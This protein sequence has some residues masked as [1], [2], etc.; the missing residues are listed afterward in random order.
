VICFNK[1]LSTIQE[2]LEDGQPVQGQLV[3]GVTILVD[4]L[5]LLDDCGLA[6]LSGACDLHHDQSA[7]LQMTMRKKKK[8]RERWKE[9]ELGVQRTQ[10]EDL[11]FPA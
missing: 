11:A 7:I 2:V 3:D 8:K 6:A 9:K 10:Q 4:N 1:G 5:H